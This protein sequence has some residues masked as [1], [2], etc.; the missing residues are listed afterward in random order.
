VGARPGRRRVPHPGTKRRTYL[1]ENAAAA[2]V[3]LDANDLARLDEIVPVDAVAGDRVRRH[4]LRGI[5][6]RAAN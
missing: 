2:D 5:E 6:A 4:A 1:D 3:V